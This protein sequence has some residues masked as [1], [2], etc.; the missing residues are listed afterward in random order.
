MNPV[1]AGLVEHPEE[2][3]YSS[4]RLNAEVD[5]APQQFQLKPRG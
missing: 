2:Y 1:K 5:P 3:P 4:A